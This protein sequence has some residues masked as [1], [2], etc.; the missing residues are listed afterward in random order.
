MPKR[1]TTGGTRSCAS[2]AVARE[3]DPPSETVCKFGASGDQSLKFG[4]FTVVRPFL[5]AAFTSFLSSNTSVASKSRA[6][7]LTASTSTVPVR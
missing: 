1:A 5:K 2:A 7:K 3:R 4:T 6:G